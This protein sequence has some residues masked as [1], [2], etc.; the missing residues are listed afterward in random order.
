MRGFG[1][2]GKELPLGEQPREV[3]RERT[4]WAVVCRLFMHTQHSACEDLAFAGDLR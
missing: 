1:V 2:C 4:L 3:L